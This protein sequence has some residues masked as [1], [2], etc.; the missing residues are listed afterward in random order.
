MLISIR[1]FSLVK[2]GSLTLACIA[3]G[4]GSTLV[5]AGESVAGPPVV[6]VESLY[7]EPPVLLATELLPADLLSGSRHAVVP[8]VPTDGFLVYFTIQ[9]DYGTFQATSTEEAVARIHEV[10]AIAA[11][12][13]MKRHQVA[14]KAVVEGVK[15][16]FLSVKEVVT[17]PSETVENFRESIG[18]W[19]GRSKLTLSKAARKTAHKTQEIVK[20]TKDAYDEKREERRSEAE[21]DTATSPRAPGTDGGDLNP[22]GETRKF[23]ELR[24]NERFQW[25]KG[26]L[27]K[28][29]YR[30]IGY[31]RARRDLAGQLKVD[32]YS[33]NLR[34]QERLDEIAWAHWAG[35][36]G[37]QFALPTDNAWVRSI[38]DINQLVWESHPK[39]LEI[40]NRQRLKNMGV[41]RGTINAFFDNPLYSPSDHTV[42]ISQ[43]Q[44]LGRVENLDYFFH[45]AQAA[46]DG[47]L[48]TFYRRSARMLS[49]VHDRWP[50]ERLVTPSETLPVALT[51]DG[52][53][54]LVLAVD[55]LA[56]SRSIAQLGEAVEHGRKEAKFE[57]KIVLLLGSD[58]TPRARHE[59][60]SLGW[61]VET[62]GLPRLAG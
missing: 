46:N 55:H 24:Q 56:W 3:M 29:S 45:L 31:D 49:R 62:W 59:F 15:E 1:V 23:D 60:E 2:R 5:A 13:E 11:L 32:P 12:V 8:E 39:D 35:G 10:Y 41:D 36:F 43:L 21:P 17:R 53:L 47:M 58:V 37:T 42:I 22:S 54:L 33:T 19:V 20:E 40:L 25:A 57:G 52:D 26:T 61:T 51:R 14:A 44:D 6:D 16:P 38:E 27:Q 30:Y 4:I 50:L 7:E 18:R 28:A 9:S 48:A 34:L